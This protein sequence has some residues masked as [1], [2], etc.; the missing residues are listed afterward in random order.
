M[1]QAKMAKPSAANQRIDPSSWWLKVRLPRNCSSYRVEAQASRTL[2]CGQW[3][4]FAVLTRSGSRQWQI[5]S[6]RTQPT[7]RFSGFEV[8]PHL[9]VR[10]FRNNSSS[11]GAGI[12]QESIV[13]VD[14]EQA[15][16]GPQ[17]E[18]GVPHGACQDHR[19]AEV[20]YGLSGSAQGCQQLGVGFKPSD[21]IFGATSSLARGNRVRRQLQR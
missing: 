12:S 8:A 21:N 4:L 18:S 2:Q 19:L 7:D 6:E 11:R 16:G 3:P 9:V 14:G 15:S 1:A 5:W 13:T 17:E 10:Q 20:R